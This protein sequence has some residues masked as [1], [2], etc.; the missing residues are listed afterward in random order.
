MNVSRTIINRGKFK[1]QRED[2]VADNF[3]CIGVELP[4]VFQKREA[5]LMQ[6]A[7][8]VISK[9]RVKIDSLSPDLRLLVNEHHYEYSVRKVG[10]LRYF[11]IN[12]SN[13]INKAQ[14]CCRQC[15]ARR[16]AWRIAEMKAQGI[17]LTHGVLINAGVVKSK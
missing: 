8:D 9:N 2:D 10:D 4:G 1:G 6:L 15:K 14:K 11:K 16:E 7:I 5:T 17:H 12:C 13:H 3:W